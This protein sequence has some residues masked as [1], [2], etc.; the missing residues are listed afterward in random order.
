M[1]EFEKYLKEECSRINLTSGEKRFGYDSW[2]A[3]LKWV[4]DMSGQTNITVLKAIL[5]EITSGKGLF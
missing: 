3:A 2:K 5:D 1:K 4:Y